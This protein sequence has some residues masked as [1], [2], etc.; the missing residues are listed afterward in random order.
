MTDALELLQWQCV[1]VLLAMG[2]VMRALAFVSM[3]L[4]DRPKQNKK[5]ASEICRLCL[6]TLWDKLHCCGKKGSTRG[7]DNSQ[8]TLP[9][10]SFMTFNPV[11]GAG[12][13]AAAPVGV[14]P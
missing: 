14:H 9:R 11:R 4:V 12:S 7:E 6:G 3:V 13:A 8:D 1:A 10:H 2:L 5:A